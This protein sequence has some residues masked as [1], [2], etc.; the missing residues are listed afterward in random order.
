MS[1]RKIYGL[2]PHDD[3]GRPIR[4]S[5]QKTAQDIADENANWHRALRRLPEVS[6]SSP[7]IRELRGQFD[8]DHQCFDGG[9]DHT[10]DKAPADAWDVLESLIGTV[11]G[12]GPLAPFADGHD[13]TD[14]VHVHD[15]VIANERQNAASERDE[16]DETKEQ[17]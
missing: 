17:P 4:P 11:D 8:N 9:C 6:N 15:H 5:R 12:P 2:Q 7:V 16:G 13:Y 3:M 10:D 1:R 14:P